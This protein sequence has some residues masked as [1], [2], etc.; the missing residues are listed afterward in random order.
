[1][2]KNLDIWQKAFPQK[3]Y[4]GD[5]LIE[6]YKAGTLSDAEVDQFTDLW[7][8]PMF[9]YHVRRNHPDLFGEGDSKHDAGVRPD[10]EDA[11]GE[12]KTVDGAFNGPLG[13]YAD[14]KNDN[15]GGIEL[16]RNP[17]EYDPTVDKRKFEMEYDEDF[18]KEIRFQDNQ[19]YPEMP[20]KLQNLQ[21]AFILR[22][23]HPYFALLI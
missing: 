20:M 11:L 13:G 2:D 6:G 5:K 23:R 16:D 14:P 4:R 19:I 15:G 18:Q 10:E 9:Q 1:M 3:V 8:D 7:I 17:N 21:Q 22:P 12:V